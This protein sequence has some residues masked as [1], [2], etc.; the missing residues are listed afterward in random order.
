MLVPVWS[1]GASLDLISGIGNCEGRASRVTL[2]AAVASLADGR[3]AAR[4]AKNSGR[5][6]QSFSPHA[7][8]TGAL[9]LTQDFAC[10]F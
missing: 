7:C 2:A 6:S 1:T 3:R 4:A 10:P 9:A 8:C 5:R